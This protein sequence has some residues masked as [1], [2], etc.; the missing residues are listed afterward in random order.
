MLCLSV[1]KKTAMTDLSALLDILWQDY[2]K[3]SPQAAAIHALLAENGSVV[4][5][6]HIALR[7]IADDSCGIE[8]L[9]AAFTPHG[10]CFAEDHYRFPEKHLRARYL[11]HADPLQPRVFISALQ[12]DELPAVLGETLRPLLSAHPPQLTQPGRPWSCQRATWQELQSHSEYA[13]WL[14]AFGWRANHFTVSLNHQQRFP[15]IDDLVAF[16]RGQG[17]AM[18]ASGGLIKG[19]AAQ[20]LRQA[21]TLAQPVSVACDD[22]KL[23]LPGCYVEFAQRY[24]MDDGQLYQG[25]IASSADRIFEST[26]NR[27][28]T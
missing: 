10:Y 26:D 11:K 12:L 17:Y 18:N 22:G 19:S 3:I 25:F 2:C 13:A 15:A 9:A 4:H 23:E 16:L 1:F 28:D 5:N 21:S 27:K 7:T 6:D 14:Y 8:A 24:P 20:G